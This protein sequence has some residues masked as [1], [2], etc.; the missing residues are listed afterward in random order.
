MGLRDEVIRHRRHNPFSRCT[1]AAVTEQITDPELRD[2]WL[3]LLVEKRPDGKY[4]AQASE[5]ARAMT[6]RGLRISQDTI[7]RHRRG[8]CAC[9]DEEQAD[10]AA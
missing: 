2:E 4:E 8:D 10:D 1:V 6:A 7:T 3:A 5:L 9:P